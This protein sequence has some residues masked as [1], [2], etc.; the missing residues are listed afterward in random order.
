MSTL[1]YESELYHHGIKGM[2]WG[3]R[4]YRNKDGSLTGAGRKR[5]KDDPDVQKAKATM[6]SNKQIKN[7]AY[8]A[9][10]LDSSSK[11]WNVYVN[12]KNKYKASKFN[13]KTAKEA[14]RL[15]E[16]GKTKAIVSAKV[17]A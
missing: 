11:N 5:Y 16:S 14:A 13:Y 17:A 8:N 12:S 4:R 7:R 1:Y 10:E 3:V 2:K 15:K 6:K 9:Y